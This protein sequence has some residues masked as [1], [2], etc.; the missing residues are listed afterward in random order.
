MGSP[1][2]HRRAGVAIATA[3]T[4]LAAALQHAV[5]MRPV[6]IAIVDHLEALR[7]LAPDLLLAIID[8]D[9][10]G[11]WDFVAAEERL[12]GVL[13]ATPFLIAAAR[14]PEWDEDDARS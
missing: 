4:T 8:V 6:E 14:P 9:Q 1:M 3:D 5:A 13:F 2:G 7:A 11:A 10:P 12:G